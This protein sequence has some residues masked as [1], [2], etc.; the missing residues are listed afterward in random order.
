MDTTN[1]RCLL[2]EETANGPELKPARLPLPRLPD[3]DVT[4]R[5]EY[6]SLNYKDALAVQGNPGVVKSLP[7]VPGIDAAGQVVTSQD[8]QLPEGSRVLVT[9]Y[10]LGQ[11]H[12]GGWSEL[13][14]VPAA[15]CV[16]LP[17]ALSTR[18]AMIL[19][20][21]GFTAAQCVMAL[22]RNGVEPDDGDLVVT[23]A[24]GGVGSLSL[25]LLARLGYPVTAVTG[26]AE[27]SQ[28]LRDAGATHVVL[29]QEFLDASKRPLLSGKWAGGVDTVGG[30]LLATLLRS[31]RYGGA[32][33]ACGLV[34]GVELEMTL[35]PFLLRGISLCGVASAD[36]PF[37]RRQ[38]I[39]RRLA[40]EWRLERLNDLVTQVSLEEMPEQVARIA[41]G[42]VSGRVLLKL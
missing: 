6:S 33:A 24:T 42:Q 34:A 23:G 10:E 20:T 31:T 35:Y 25:R 21:A 41:A 30:S 1:F 8:P 37:A 2:V 16:P 18:E 27:Q 28:A 9:G 36:C 29:R 39:W 5:V 15:W 13:I 26:K 3:G 17:E 40:N 19:G 38:E 11:S 12:W 14:R 22:Q 32:V 7:H 4:I